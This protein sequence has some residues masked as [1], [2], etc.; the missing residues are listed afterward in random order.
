MDIR[1]LSVSITKSPTQIGLNKEFIS[2]CNSKVQRAWF[3]Y[4]YQTLVLW[5]C[6]SL[7]SPLYPF[8]SSGWLPW[9]VQDDCF[10]L[11]GLHV[12]SFLGE[13]KDAFYKYNTKIL[14]LTIDYSCVPKDHC[15]KIWIPWTINC[16][17]LCLDHWLLNLSVHQS[18]L[19]DV[20][21]HRLLGPTP[22]FLSQHIWGWVLRTCICNK[23]PDVT[24]LAGLQTTLWEPLLCQI[25]TYFWSWGRVSPA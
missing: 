17:F 9:A 23:F 2:S 6:V 7:S 18:H 15:L 20:L 13:K 8:F 16:S 25:R 3:D 24:D 14:S 21:K 22:E 10:W 1:I 5:F 4:D 19:E 12:F 11:L